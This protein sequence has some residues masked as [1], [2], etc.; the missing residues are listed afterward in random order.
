MSERVVGPIVVVGDVMNDVVVRPQA[1]V[2]VATD[3]SSTIDFTFG[4]SAANQA[5]WLAALGVDTRFAV[6]R[7][8][9]ADAVAHRQALQQLG[10][11]VRLAWDVLLLHRHFCRFGVPGRGTLDV[12]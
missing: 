7:A 3:T 9:A 8:G 1:P 10:V 4:G 6:N 11:D 2:D 5:A 12:H